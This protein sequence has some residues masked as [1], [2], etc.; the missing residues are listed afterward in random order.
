MFKVSCLGLF[1]GASLF[2]FAQNP[3][4]LGE[5]LRTADP[6]AHVWEDGRLY[7]YTSH[8]MEC[9]EDFWMQDWY[10]FSSTDL[11]NWTNHGPSLSLDEIAWADNYAWAPDAAYKNGKYYL[12]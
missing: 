9:Q 2:A 10:T 12:D 11:V 4:P 3:L 7:L 8:D 6:S 5:G 1:M